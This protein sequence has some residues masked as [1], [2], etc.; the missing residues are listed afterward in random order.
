MKP[1]SLELLD[2]IEPLD[3]V[4]RIKQ[5]WTCILNI[6]QVPSFVPAH[7]EAGILHLRQQPRLAF[8]EDPKERV[9]ELM[10]LRGRPFARRVGC[11]VSSP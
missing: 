4:P 7:I 5:A 2:M 6:Q 1:V 11:P 3:H 8:I 10:T 9:P